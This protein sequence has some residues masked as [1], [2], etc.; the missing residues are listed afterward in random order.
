MTGLQTSL[1]L[2]FV[3]VAGLFNVCLAVQGTQQ[4]DELE[5]NEVPH[6]Q[7]QASSNAF[8]SWG[9]RPDR[10]TGKGMMRRHTEPQSQTELVE[11]RGLGDV[12]SS[13]TRDTQKT[14][15][16]LRERTVI[17]DSGSG[18]DASAGD[19]ASTEIDEQDSL[20]AGASQSTDAER[21][22]I[23]ADGQD[24]QTETEY[25][26]R[27]VPSEEGTLAVDDSNSQD[28]VRV[29]DDEMKNKN[30]TKK[31][32]AEEDEAE[33]EAGGEEEVGEEDEYEEEAE[34]EQH[35]EKLEGSQQPGS[36]TRERAA[37]SA[38]V[39]KP[40]AENKQ[41]CIYFPAYKLKPPNGENG[42]THSDAE[43]YEACLAKCKAN[44]CNQVQWTNTTSSDGI[45]ITNCKTF[46]GYA[47]EED[48]NLENDTVYMAA[49]CHPPAGD[50][51]DQGP[52]GPVGPQGP[53]GPKGEDGPTGENGA[54]GPDGA[55]G[56]AGEKG[57]DGFDGPDGNEASVD[58]LATFGMVYGAFALSIAASIGTF[59][60][61]QSKA[62]QAETK[63]G[64]PEQ[65]GE[66][67]AEEEEEGEGVEE[68]E[69]EE[70]TAYA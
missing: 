19:D 58:G 15:S 23:S 29:A 50:Q 31:K 52:P 11:V 6:P 7:H 32:E 8:S 13:E 47:V 38:R 45:I 42:K 57:E 69:A 43:T 24:F 55:K 21:V 33:E 54:D 12:S 18:A 3:F 34:E 48:E 40:P 39:L 60:A 5:A 41:V 49:I 16:A 20:A 36:D 46:K 35:D 61:I 25:V 17:D 28:E 67:G 59:V 30:K 44:V 14:G 65:E 4:K 63:S 9:V 22:S 26:E 68:E 51:G 62:A 70:E 10:S 1:T 56:A 2:W 53:A 27:I 66:M 64:E 37:V